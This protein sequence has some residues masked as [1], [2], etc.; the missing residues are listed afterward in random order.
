VVRAHRIAG[1]S[2]GRVNPIPEQDQI[3]EY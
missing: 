3:E 1:N 2:D